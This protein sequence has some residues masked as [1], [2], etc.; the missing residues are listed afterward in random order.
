[1]LLALSRWSPWPSGN[2][3]DKRGLETHGLT[4]SNQSL[5]LEEGAAAKSFRRGGRHWPTEHRI[6]SCGKRVQLESLRSSCSTRRALASPRPFPRDPKL[7]Y[8]YSPP[9]PLLLVLYEDD[10]ISDLVLYEDDFI[11]NLV[12]MVGK[13]RLEQRGASERPPSTVGGGRDF[14][15]QADE[16]GVAIRLADRP[17]NTTSRPS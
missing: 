12:A 2:W 1:M 14:E 4:I 16:Q 13:V 5:T 3:R 11:S 9:S 7:L 6:Q 10:F 8:A 17:T 15:E